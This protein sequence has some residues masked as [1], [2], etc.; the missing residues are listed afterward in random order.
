M[1]CLHG[2]RGL[3]VKQDFRKHSLLV[4]MAFKRPFILPVH[5]SMY[6]MVLY[7]CQENVTMLL[8]CMSTGHSRPHTDQHLVFV[9]ITSSVETAGSV[10]VRL[11]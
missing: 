3:P 7:I 2:A 11:S 1:L 10:Q 6:T 5:R 4:V 8:W 9:M